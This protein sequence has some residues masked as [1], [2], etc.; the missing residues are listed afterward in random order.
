MSKTTYVTDENNKNGKCYNWLIN[1]DDKYIRPFLI[2][3]YEIYIRNIKQI[4]AV[5]IQNELKAAKI[6]EDELIENLTINFKSK[7]F[8]ND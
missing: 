5:D 8:N 7:K 3:K 2:Y 1:F 6:Q 4:E